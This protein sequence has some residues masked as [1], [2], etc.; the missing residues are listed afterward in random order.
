[1]IALMAVGPALPWGRAS[2]E[3]AWVRFAV[4]LGGAMLTP[5]VLFAVSGADILGKPYVLLATSLCVFALIANADEFLL[6]VRQR[7]RAKKEAPHTAIWAVAR[8]GRRRFGGHI[9]HLGVIMA[10]LSMA[11][12]KG[13]R[14]EA[15]FTTGPGH[16]HEFAEYTLEF[17][18][19]EI[20]EEG[21][22]RGVIGVFRLSRDSVDMGVYRPRINHYA[23]RR[24]PLPAP[25]SLSRWDHDLQLTLMSA[26]EDGSFAYLRVI[27]TPFMMWLW[28]AAF[29]I[30]AGT[31][32]SV[33]P[34]RKRED[35]QAAA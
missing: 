8:R 13:Y 7:M 23:A 17:E 30:V 19:T 6:P 12:A 15:Y 4:P 14:A 35:Q 28:F 21:F 2:V 1:L 5:V 11:A 25:A 27:R 20:V 18:G 33:W 9:A 31:T 10:V 29:V 24:E 32:L 3:R 22:R 26:E 34:S 16:A